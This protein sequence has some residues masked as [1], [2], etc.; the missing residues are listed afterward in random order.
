MAGTPDLFRTAASASGSSL[1]RQPE[2]LE[3]GELLFDDATGN[4][5]D[6]AGN[7]DDVT[8]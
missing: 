5:D 8:S 1:F 7:F 4:F 6:K 2:E 3:P